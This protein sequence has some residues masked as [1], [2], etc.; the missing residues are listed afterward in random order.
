M[1]FRCL[2]DEIRV[3]TAGGIS[4]PSQNNN[5][6]RGGEVAVEVVEVDTEYYMIF[7]IVFKKI[8]NL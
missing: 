6:E 4:V 1:L 2:F 8:C 5:F 7:Q 3:N